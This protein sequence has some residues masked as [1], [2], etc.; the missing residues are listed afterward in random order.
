MFA[1]F[2]ETS[3][4]NQ[5]VSKLE[6]YFQYCVEQN[7]GYK[8]RLYSIMVLD[9]YFKTISHLLNEVGQVLCCKMG[10]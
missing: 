6:V 5:M 2:G 9:S 1:S 8:Y 4:T 7:N 10:K 3:E